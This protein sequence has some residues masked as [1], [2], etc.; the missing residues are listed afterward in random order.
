MPEPVVNFSRSR[1]ATSRPAMFDS[2][3]IADRDTGFRARRPGRTGSR[4]PALRRHAPART[5]TTRP[6]PGRLHRALTVIRPLSR[7]ATEEVSVGLVT[8]ERWGDMVATKQALTG[9][10]L[11]PL[12]HPDT[13]ARLGVEPPK[14]FCCTAPGC[15]KTFVVRAL[16]SSGRLSV[17]AVKGAELDGQVGRLGSEKAV[18]NCSAGQGISA[19]SLIFHRTK[20]T[21]SHRDV[22]RASTQVSAGRGGHA[23]RTGRHR[24]TARRRRPRRH[25]LPAGLST[26][27]AA[28]RPP[29]EAG[30]RRN[31]R[32]P[33]RVATSCAPRRKV[34]ATELDVDLE[35][36]RVSWTVIAPPTASPVARR[37]H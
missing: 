32:M 22:A 34:G 3:D 15:G 8:L 18:R 20:S 36:W 13:F 37:P 6:G 24:A 23:D 10:V 26:R 11:W 31:R 21:R 17:H 4:T 14:G 30:V 9:A 28:A 12:Q 25:E 29:G 33:R 2:R 27:A 1:C 19:P 7:S 35:C 5:A 16:A